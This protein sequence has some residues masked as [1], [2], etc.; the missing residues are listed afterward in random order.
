MML[1]NTVLLRWWQW[2]Y[3]PTSTN[4]LWTHFMCTCLLCR[5]YKKV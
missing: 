1:Y 2:S 4:V 3:E 5:Y